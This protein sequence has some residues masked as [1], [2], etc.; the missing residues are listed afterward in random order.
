MNTT[1][2]IL[3]LCVSALTLHA[4]TQ[5]RISATLSYQSGPITDPTPEL[6][7]GV[8]FL[9]HYNPDALSDSD[10]SATVGQFSGRAAELPL[11]RY[12]FT[13]GGSYIDWT[14]GTADPASNIQIINQA[15]DSF[16]FSAIP[17]NGAGTYWRAEMHLEDG[18]GQLFA[19]DSLPQAAFDLTD[20]SG[21]TF[22]FI[23][24]QGGYAPY[25]YKV[26]DFQIAIVPEPSVFALVTGA[27]AF[28]AL[29][30][31]VRCKST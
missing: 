14:D 30:I 2:V 25:V 6:R 16:L 19:N 17:I 11:V 20:L 27:L 21:A 5:V 9:L 22:S 15:T 10:V 12:F 24:T 23:D 7:R 1:A 26:S 3:A 8:S 29:S 4:Q 31:R 18:T 28:L 13:P